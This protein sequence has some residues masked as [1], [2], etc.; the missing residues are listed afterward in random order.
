MPTLDWIGKDKV[1]NHHNDVPYRMLERK[2]SYDKS[3]V[4][5][6]DNY[7]ENMIIHGDNLEALKALLPQYEGKIKCIYIDPPY[8]TAKS[9]EKNKAWVYSDNVDDPKIMRW[10]GNT[11][12]D[13]GEDLS[14]H[15]KWLC[16]MYPRLCLL[17]KL[18]SYDG[19]VFISIDDNECANLRIICDEIFGRK[20]FVAQLVW[21]SDGNFDNQAKVKNIHEYVLC[22]TKEPSILGLP[23]GVDPNAQETSK[24]F[25][26]QIRNTVVKN[27]PKNPASRILLPSGFPCTETSL[28]IKKRESSFPH[29][30][31]DAVIEN[32][33]LVNSVEVE[34]GWSSK[35]ILLDFINNGFKSVK[36]S[37]KQET[38]FEITKTGAIEMV[39]K[40]ERISHVI[41]IL[42]NL[43]STQNM[44][45]ELKKMGIEFDFPKPVAMIEY[46]LGFYAEKDSVVLDSFAGSGTTAHAVLNMNKV[47]GGNRKFIL[48]EM[49][50]Y[51]NDITAERVK[52]VISGYGEGK[53]VA[54][55]TGG[56]FSYYELGETLFLPDG[57]LNNNVETADIRR[58]IWYT[59]TN[60]VEYTEINDEEYYLGFH[61]DTAYYFYFEKDGTT[62]LDYK[63]LTGVR[64][65]QQAYIIYADSCALS[66][67]D[68]QRWNIT[69]KKIPRDIEHI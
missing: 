41:S 5:D 1:I 21:R 20:N 19:I 33:K 39:K 25:N 32:G 6:E 40:R 50:D 38:V 24:V 27:G 37:K 65:K 49:G 8:N 53:N 13:E 52:R 43:G 55:G 56:D 29:Y 26:D 42:Q 12:G 59:E 31:Q 44:S 9:S 47:D 62:V 30:I 16:M 45:T 35:N 48:V 64:V 15:D 51:A 60:G 57:T 4:H 58:Y 14:R 17:Q 10:L 3:G 7:S 18:L 34:S 66:E 2:Y 28:V 63:F 54:Q 22:Y 46:L 67:S 61:N 23:N 69:F 68:L 36:D 11:V